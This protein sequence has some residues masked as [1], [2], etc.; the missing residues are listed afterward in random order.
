MRT[1]VRRGKT[2]RRLAGDDP[3]VNEEWNCDKGRWAFKYEVAKNRITTPLVRD[4]NGQLQEASWPEA[5][6][7]AAK[8]LKESRA[9]VLVGGRATVEDAYGYSK[10]ARVTLATNNIDFRSRVSSKEELDFLASVP[11]NATYKDIDNA[12]H[13]VLINFEPEDESPIVFLRI[14]KQVHKRSIKVTTIAALASRGSQKLKANLIKTAAGDEVS[15]INSISGLTGK[16]VVLVGERAAETQGALSAVAKLVKESGAKLGWVPR[17]AGERGA[18]AAGALP[19]LLPGARPIE[20]ASARVDIATAW[21]V[22]SVPTTAGMSTEEIINSDLQAILIGGV[23]PMDISSDAK[24]KLAKKFIVS[25]EIRQSDITEIASVVLP[26]AAVVEKSGSFMDWQGKVRKFDAAVEQSL[27]RSDVRILSMLADEIGKPINLPT[28][29]SAQSELSSLGNWDGNKPTMNLLAE[30]S[31]TSAG[32]DEAILTSWRNLLDK[33]SLQ[34]GEENLAGTAR[35]S[36]VVISKNRANSLG[37]KDKELVRV[38]NNYG[39]V[40]LPCLV[41]DIEDSSVWLPR[42]SVNSQLIRNLGV[43]G[44]SIVKVAK[45]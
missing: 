11:T 13:V 12:D 43:V 22:D 20:D 7:A 27:N 41:E 25:L 14:Y 15:A 42:N 18:I 26:V 1:D 8:G 9:G 2:L 39:A 4:A 30:K 3:Q 21:S 16:S 6:A 10:F 31:K 40:T 23:D 45:A 34:D 32:N 44:N 36:V 28:V 19:N 5:L 38:S 17:R 33:G 35:D 24:V 37:V 29:K